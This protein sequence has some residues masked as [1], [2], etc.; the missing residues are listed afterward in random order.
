MRSGLLACGRPNSSCRPAPT[1]RATGGRGSPPR[2]G[3]GGPRG[4][5][6][7]GPP[8][9]P[10]TP[11]PPPSA[12]VWPA[13]PPR[14]GPAVYAPLELDGPE[15]GARIVGEHVGESWQDVLRGRG[16]PEGMRAA[17]PPRPVAAGA[18]G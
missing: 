14:G 2:G 16:E 15:L 7:P 1:R 11:P 5:A 8:P 3:A 13:P 17:P 9:P 10:R 12:A 18:A 6:P 4:G